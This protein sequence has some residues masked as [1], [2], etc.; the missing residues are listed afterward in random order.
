MPDTIVTAEPVSAL[1]RRITEFDSEIVITSVERSAFNEAKGIE[2]INELSVT[3][4]LIL[5]VV[6]EQK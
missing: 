3:D 5:H 2:Y 4:P 6:L 1:A